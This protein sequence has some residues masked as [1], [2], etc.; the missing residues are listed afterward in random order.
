MLLFL[1]LIPYFIVFI[2][3][4]IIGSFLNVCIYRLPLNES[5]V[6]APSHCMSC[7]SKLKWYDM[8]PV[9]SWIILGGR[10]RNCK[11]KI[12]VQYPII[13][14][15]NGALYVLVFAV[16]GWNATSIVYCLMTSGLIVLSVIDWRSYEIPYI[17]NG[18]L[19]VL[20]VVTLFLEFPDWQTYVFGAACVSGVLALVYV[21]SDGS[22]VGGGDVKLMFTCGLILG[23]YRII[24]AFFLACIVASI[25]HL[26]LMRFKNAG[27]MLA[28]GPYLSIGIFL[29]AIWGNRWINWYLS[30]LWS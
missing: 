5:V 6:T 7:G 13:E 21:L 25:T 23:W 3:G 19:F 4:T 10:C 2:F 15:L 29:A 9:F 18:Y 22:L 26:I 17:V 8:V 24:L 14:A 12:S 20:G 30:I 27:N 16:K 28:M 11:T 1:D